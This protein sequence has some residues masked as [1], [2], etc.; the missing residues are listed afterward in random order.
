MHDRALHMP[1]YELAFLWAIGPRV[2]EA[3]VEP[4]QG[5]LVLHAL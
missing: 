4:H 1:V 3:R 5:L 2:E